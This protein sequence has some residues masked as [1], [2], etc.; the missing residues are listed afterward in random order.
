MTV[1]LPVPAS[2][3][4]TA[5]GLGSSRDNSWPTRC[6]T[7][8]FSPAQIAR[9][10]D[11]AREHELPLKLH[12]E[13]LS[14]C[15]GAALAAR[16]KSEADRKAGA[17]SA[18]EP[19]KSDDLALRTSVDLVY[20]TGAP[21]SAPL[22]PRKRPHFWFPD[23]DQPAAVETQAP[24]PVFETAIEPPPEQAETSPAGEETSADEPSQA[25][26]A[27]VVR[28]VRPISE[29]AAAATIANTVSAVR[30][31]EREAA[32]GSSNGSKKHRAK[33]TFSNQIAYWRAQDK[34]AQSEGLMFW[35]EVALLVLLLAGAS[36]GVVYFATQ[37]VAGL[38]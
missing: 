36:W 31:V 13:Q 7:I 35:V 34:K 37:P 10:C 26:D 32:S 3:T 19:P 22:V 17:A 20:P 18:V 15:G 27:G 33:R 28:R 1:S 5:G 14:S 29:A 21:P 12:A 25:Q 38:R 16:T 4:R 23:T 8:A 11:A 24:E 2:K 6:E 30:V 9:V